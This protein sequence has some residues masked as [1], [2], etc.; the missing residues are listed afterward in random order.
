MTTQNTQRFFPYTNECAFLDNNKR[1]LLK[2]AMRVA[3]EENLFDFLSKNQDGHCCSHVL[4]KLLPISIALGNECEGI[5]KNDIIWSQTFFYIISMLELIAR[6]GFDE[7]ERRY[8]SSRAESLSPVLNNQPFRIGQMVLTKINRTEWS[9]GK[10]VTILE[11][12]MYVIQ[13]L[14]N[15]SQMIEYGENIK[16]LDTSKIDLPVNPDFSFISDGHTRRMIE[17]GYKAVSQSEGWN[18]LREFTGMSFMFSDDPNIH[19]IM[20]AVDNAY[21]G[22]HSG[23]SIGFTMRKLERISHIGLNAFKNEYIEN[24]QDH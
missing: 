20:T 17:S 2:V 7:F 9:S 5:V 4:P 8:T 19:R 23:S 10:I 24:H 13:L 16:E 21:S 22:G 3:N 18:I 6:E 1:T 14:E 12:N 15:A 11:D